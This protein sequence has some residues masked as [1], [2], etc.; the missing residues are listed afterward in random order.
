VTPRLV[1][2]PLAPVVSRRRQ[3]SLPVAASTAKGCVEAVMP[4][5]MPLTMIGLHC[6]CPESRVWYSQATF[7]RLTL[8]ALIWVSGE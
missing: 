5:R 2:R 7:S 3:I 1:L 8:P 6:T 4:Y